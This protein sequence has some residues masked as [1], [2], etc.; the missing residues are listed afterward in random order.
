M[1]ALHVPQNVKPVKILL[2]I[3]QNVKQVDQTHQNVSAQMENLITEI[4]VNLVAI[5]VLPV[6]MEKIVLNVLTPELMHLNVIV[7]MD[8]MIKVK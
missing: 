8:I 4:S 6:P 2:I 1:N 7:P 5:N 3:A